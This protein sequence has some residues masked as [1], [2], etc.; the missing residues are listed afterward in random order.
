MCLKLYA[1]EQA[2][3]EMYKNNRCRKL[4]YFLEQNF[5]YFE[6]ND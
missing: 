2:K 4:N 5:L 6:F 3:C 1:L